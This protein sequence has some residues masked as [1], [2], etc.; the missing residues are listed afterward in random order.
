M[1]ANDAAAC[2]LYADDAVLVLPGSGAITG[3][4][5]RPIEGHLGAEEGSP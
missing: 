1:L 3:I 2:A 5:L 4:R